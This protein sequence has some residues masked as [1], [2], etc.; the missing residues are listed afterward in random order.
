VEVSKTHVGPHQITLNETEGQTKICEASSSLVKLFLS[1]YLV[2]HRFDIITNLQ[3][4][5]S[6][7]SIYFGISA[8]DPAAISP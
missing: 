8:S 7:S 5:N 3:L 2:C 4:F 1:L 6:S